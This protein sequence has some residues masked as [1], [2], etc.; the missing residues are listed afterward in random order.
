MSIILD[1]EIYNQVI[2]QKLANEQTITELY[3]NFDNFTQ[4]EKFIALDMITDFNIIN[5]EFQKYIV[6]Y[7]QSVQSENHSNEY[8]VISGDTIHSI[9]QKETGDYQ[10]WKKIME[11]NSLSDLELEVGTIILIPRNL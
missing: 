11:F 9:A 8:I 10:N 5:E 4:E 6:I 1:K 2:A 7:N 3:A